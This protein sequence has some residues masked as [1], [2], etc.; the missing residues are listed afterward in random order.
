MYKNLNPKKGHEKLSNKSSKSFDIN[1]LETWINET[2]RELSE[3]L[4]TL[5]LEEV[6]DEI[7]KRAEVVPLASIN[8]LY[9]LRH[10]QADP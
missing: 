2:L 4:S 10:R 8:G 6:F 1:V 3:R 7:L 5:I 9:G